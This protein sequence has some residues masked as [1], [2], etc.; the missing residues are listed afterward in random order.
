MSQIQH[1]RHDIILWRVHERHIAISDFPR[2]SDKPNLMFKVRLGQIFEPE[3]EW[4]FR[5]GV[6][7]NPNFGLW[8][9]PFLRWIIQELGWCI[10]INKI[11]KQITLF[12]FIPIIDLH[13]TTLALSFRWPVLA[14]VGFSWPALAVIGLCWVL[15]GLRSLLWAL[16]G[17]CW[18]SDGLCWLL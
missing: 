5:F 6:R 9:E 7:A 2:F 16:V 13:Y 15:G 10:K 3:P 14:V 11:Y 8:T 12:K 4:R 18:H 1:Y 17:L